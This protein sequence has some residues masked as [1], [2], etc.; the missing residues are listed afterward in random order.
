MKMLLVVLLIVSG[1]N[2]FAQSLGKMP[3]S[4]RKIVDEYTGVSKTVN[5]PANIILS[6]DQIKTKFISLAL[7]N[8]QITAFGSKYRIFLSSGRAGRD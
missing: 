2:I 7:K 3:D 6:E 8:A 4:V 1:N 5:P